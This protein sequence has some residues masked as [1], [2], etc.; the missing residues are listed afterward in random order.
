MMYIMMI[1]EQLKDRQ[2]K[3]VRRHVE[4]QEQIR[5]R[6]TGTVCSLNYV[7]CMVV[8][9]TLGGLSTNECILCR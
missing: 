2:I 4:T 3:N 6:I 8:K 5:L 9:N 7:K 1:S